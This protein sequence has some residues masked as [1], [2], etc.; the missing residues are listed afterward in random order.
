MKR[1]KKPK[2]KSI[3]MLITLMV[4]V[5]AI[6]SGIGNN[7]VNA[8]DIE[9]LDG[10]LND[11]NT[12]NDWIQTRGWY[13][14]Q[15][16]ILKVKPELDGDIADEDKDRSLT[17]PKFQTSS[18]VIINGPVFCIDIGIEDY[19]ITYNNTNASYILSTYTTSVANQLK[20]IVGNDVA[21]KQH[22]NSNNWSIEKQVA[23]WAIL[24]GW[25]DAQIEDY[26]RYYRYT[27]NKAGYNAA[28]DPKPDDTYVD[29]KE[30]R[31]AVVRL[32]DGA[33]K[34]ANS[35]ANTNTT[36]PTISANNATIEV[37]ES[38]KYK[39]GPFKLNYSSDSS[40]KIE[41]IEV[42][43]DKGNFTLDTNPYL[44]NGSRKSSIPSSGTEFYI[45]VSNSSNSD[46]VKK[47]TLTYGYET[48]ENIKL[49]QLQPSSKYQPLV[50][51]T[52]APDKGQGKNSVDLNLKLLEDGEYT[53]NINKIDS[54]NK[55]VLANA[56]FEV[57]VDG[58]SIGTYKTDSNGTFTE[59]IKIA[60]KE[61]GTDIIEITETSA[62]ENYEKLGESLILEV[63]TEEY[64]EE[65]TYKVSSV[66][67]TQD[68]KNKDGAAA[69]T[70]ISQT[71]ETHKQISLSIKNE[72]KFI[73]L[74]GYVWEDEKASK[75]ST[76]NGQKDV[77]EKYISGLKVT[78]HTKDNA[79]II[80]TNSPIMNTTTNSEGYYEFEVPMGP[81]YYIEF[82]YNG[83]NYQHTKYSIWGTNLFNSR[84]TS[85]ATETEVARNN[86]NDAL[87]TITPNMVVNGT[88]ISN[89]INEKG[90]TYI[91]D[92]CYT[93]SAY[94]GGYG[95]AHDIKY[96]SQTSTNINLG[97]TRREVVD[98]AIRKDVVEATLSINGYSQ[99]YE[100]NRR[101]GLETDANGNSYWEVATRR[102]DVY[103]GTNYEREVKKADYN[104]TGENKL[105][106][107][108]TYRIT[109]RNQSEVAD[110]KITELVDYYD[111]D[112]TFK[113][114]YILN[115]NT[116]TSISSSDN[117]EHSHNT[118]I[119]SY[120]KKYFDISNYTIKESSDLVIYV[121]FNVNT[122]NEGK[123]SLDDD[124]GKGNIVE[125]MDYKAA[126][127]EHT[128][129]PNNQDDREVSPLTPITY[130]EYKT[131]DIVGK[132]ELDS[133]PGNTTSSNENTFEDDTDRAPYIKFRLPET[134]NERTV[135][136]SVWQDSRTQV[137]DNAAVGNGIKDEGEATLADVE[138]Q[139]IDA[140]TNAIAKVFDG[141]NWIDAKTT[142]T[143][144]G[145]AIKGFIPGK[146]YLKFIYQDGQNYKSTT[147]NWTE[148]NPDFNI[149][150][151]DVPGALKETTINY[152]DAR[153][154]W[155]NE[156]TQG[157]R[158]YVNKQYSGIIT[159]K[160]ENILVTDLANGSHKMEAIT[161]YITVG[162]EKDSSD[163]TSASGRLYEFA[164]IDFGI[165]ER[166]KAQ[167]MLKK[168]VSNV[169]VILANGSTLFDASGKA[170]NVM[171]TNQ[172]TH[173]YGYDDNLMKQPTIRVNNQQILLTMD[174]ELMHGATIKITYKITA[175]N[176]GEVDY[177]SKQ[178]Y[179]Q[180]Q[181]NGNEPIITTVVN[182]IVDYAGASA[183]D[184]IH[185][186][187]NNLKFNVAENTG[188]E[189]ITA[190][191]LINN[192]LVKL[193]DASEND[194][195]EVVKQYN[196]IL[197]YT[198]NKELLPEIANADES[199]VETT[200]TLSQVMSSDSE[201]DNLT[202]NNMV[203]L[204]SFE[205]GIG[206]KLQYSTVG[207]QNPNEALKE[208]DSD[209]TQV[210]ILPPFGQQ[211]IY[212]ILGAMVAIILVGGIVII[213]KKVINK[214]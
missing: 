47:V 14:L 168:E 152:S 213:K 140:N 194:V 66:T 155:G 175:Q 27:T 57:K 23:V 202:Y 133:N 127:G 80:Y 118:N 200:L 171:W 148:V 117:S 99:M 130:T 33:R 161:G 100:Y 178:F 131:G 126:Y 115:G 34:Y 173:N 70:I 74:S 186:T 84:K 48:Y 199:K 132:V 207:N 122:D 170:T 156:T 206:R 137:V 54:T 112:Y 81:E 209:I 189:I 92:E 94:T 71:N 153:D 116:K 67:M 95:N 25:N 6:L 31:E 183:T 3:I 201:A 180:G 63:K 37:Y 26:A 75:E 190:D 177:A 98:L 193:V 50:L 192:G 39:I 111:K 151:P 181:K 205:N 136:G 142:S 110:C 52:G 89:T 68:F 179:Y 38:N 144:D 106:A 90:A 135:S 8:G 72:R 120:N 160:E 9:V 104:F 107:Q 158:T 55:A 203:E 19:A 109:I 174:E 150:N 210:T 164:N 187:V 82:T 157:T 113:E 167:I 214:K 154:L 185:S 125:I 15:E 1:E 58:T 162:M 169:Q 41:K 73:K 129:S 145:Y 119:E 30:I 88:K 128:K 59:P 141:N 46:V 83:Q 172:P 147:Y 51:V 163:L 24:G 143:A 20:Y 96:Y 138:V 124:I 208:V 49:Y 197:K 40:K 105:S 28:Q 103:Y 32:L 22:L 108:V 4:T 97:L 114:V 166:P 44:Y 60:I 188:W 134:E 62:P 13:N 86:L 212:Y 56:Q 36:I 11:G 43:G 196:T 35:I 121:V 79:N 165:Q 211:Y 123:I 45:I 69:G 16:G 21:S 76:L 101:Q 146:Y 93:I 139:L 198:F 12:G 184:D 149:N 65:N 77:N 91:Q 195:T 53:L 17:F 159:N 2:I 204:L 85:N 78:L 176:I 7:Y 18:G 5:V 61:A 42:I 102:S 29:E 87:G 191:T 182:D 64:P 10:I